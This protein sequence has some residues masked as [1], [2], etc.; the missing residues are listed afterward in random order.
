MFYLVLY[1]FQYCC[2]VFCKALRAALCM[3]GAIQIKCIII[4]RLQSKQIKLCEYLMEMI[5][6]YKMQDTP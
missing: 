2:Y 1:L 3:K 4:I 6:E 5:D